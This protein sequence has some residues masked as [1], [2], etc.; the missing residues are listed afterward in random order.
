MPSEVEL[1]ET[2]VRGAA[3]AIVRSWLAGR[4][5]VRVIDCECYPDGHHARHL[6]DD[7]ETR[8]SGVY[9]PLVMRNGEEV[10]PGTWVYLSAGRT[11][12]DLPEGPDETWERNGN[13]VTLWGDPPA[14]PYDA[15]HDPV[16]SI[17]TSTRDQIRDEYGHE[18][19]LAEFRNRVMVK[20]EPR[21][22]G[23]RPSRHSDLPGERDC[24]HAEGDDVA[25]YEF[26]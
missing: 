12:V 5:V 9:V 6:V 13:Q 10:S 16:P 7:E 17:Y 24:V 20:R 23:S 19:T 15:P 22:D 26:C 3:E 1:I 4:T 11:V 21:G 2:A 25:F 14:M 8:G 18:H